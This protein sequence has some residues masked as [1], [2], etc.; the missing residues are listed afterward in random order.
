MSDCR[1][2][3]VCHRCQQSGHVSASC[4]SSTV[5]YKC[6]LPGHL[7]MGCTAS[8]AVSGLRQ[9]GVAT[10][11]L[12]CKMPGHYASDCPSEAVCNN[13]L[14]AGHLARDCNAT[15]ACNTCG[16]AGHLARNCP[17]VVPLTQGSSCH[18]CGMPGHFARNCPG[19][20][21]GGARGFGGGVSQPCHITLPFSSFSC[22]CTTHDA[23]ILNGFWVLACSGSG[24][25]Q[26]EHAVPQL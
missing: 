10:V 25:R 3:M 13:C 18:S 4:P 21:V 14:M 20:G 17:G 12:N 5:C 24:G 2:E 23:R 7:A 22:A 26:H 15:K 9:G 8:A 6:G 11:C 1:A 16:Q 19:V